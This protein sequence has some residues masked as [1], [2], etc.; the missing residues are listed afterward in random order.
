M[1]FS[2]VISLPTFRHVQRLQSITRSPVFSHFSE[3]ISG[4][5]SIRA[6]GARE[7]FVRTLERRVDV[8][9]NCGYHASALDW[10][11]FFVF[12]PFVITLLPKVK[13]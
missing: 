9:I 6:F 13:V 10:Y 2:Q 1:V 12:S 3:T 5:V 4:V 11:V 8:N 7:M